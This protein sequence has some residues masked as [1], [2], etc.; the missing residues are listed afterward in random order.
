MIMGY[1]LFSLLFSFLSLPFYTWKKK[2]SDNTWYYWS[3]FSFL[4][5]IIFLF[6]LPLFSLLFS[7][8]AP[9][10]CLHYIL[11]DTCIAYDRSG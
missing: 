3:F 4:L 5:L 8:F 7:L 9:F 10:L 6:C 2:R 1:V 11:P